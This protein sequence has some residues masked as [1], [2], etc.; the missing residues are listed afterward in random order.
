MPNAEVTN[1]AA[2]VE[3]RAALA[4]FAVEVRQALSDIGIEA[5]RGLAWITND[6]PAYWRAEQR[7]S[8]DLVAHA[9]QDLAQARTYKRI[10][11][12]VPTC[13]EEKKAL[14][15]AKRRLEN[16]ERKLEIV[17]QYGQTAHRAVDEFQGPVQQ[18]L[19]IVNGDIP[20]AMAVLERMS[21][22]LA[23]YATM[24]APTAITWDTLTGKAAQSMAQSGDESDAPPEE[25]PAEINSATPQSIT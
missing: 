4:T 9:K 6:R 24:A 22:F 7:R 1:V 8:A 15:M 10:D 2:L 21:E 12:Y 20:H 18:L 5:Q 11:N 23:Q 3:F 19:A 16:A 13:A 25:Q 17:R 14:E